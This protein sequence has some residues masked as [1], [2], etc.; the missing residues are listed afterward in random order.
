MSWL[1]RDTNLT[2]LLEVKNVGLDRVVAEYKNQALRESF[3]RFL[4]SPLQTLRGPLPRE[5]V[6]REVS[7]QIYPGEKIGLL[8]RNGAGKTTLCRLIAGMMTPPSGQITFGGEVE[9]IFD[10]Q[11]M[12]MPELTGRENAQLFQKLFFTHSPLS[13][14]QLDEALEFSEL[15]EKLDRPYKTYSKGMQARLTLS[16][17]TLSTTDLLILD[18]VFDGADQFFRAKIEMRMKEKIERA[19]ALLFVSHS[20]NQILDLCERVI[21]LEKGRLVFDGPTQEGLDFYRASS[22]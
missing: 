10:T 16:L 7:F 3:I 17:L 15:G 20:E 2:P 1:S 5:S 4:K 13:Q 21:I 9:A 11:A 18:E 8:G 19:K 22:L 12:I 6:L 14:T